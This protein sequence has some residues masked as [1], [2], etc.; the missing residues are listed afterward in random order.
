M[1][2]RSERVAEARRSTD[3]FSVPDARTG[4]GVSVLSL[5][6][7]KETDRDRACALPQ[8]ATGQ[9]LVPEPTNETEKGTGTDQGTQSGRPRWPTFVT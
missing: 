4:K 6:D 9:D 3:I 1:C 5:P 7:A 8:R 2:S